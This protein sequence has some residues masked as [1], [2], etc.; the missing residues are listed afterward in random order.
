[1]YNR[2]YITGEPGGKKGDKMKKD[3]M[4]IAIPVAISAMTLGVLL[5]FFMVPR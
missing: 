4:I 5:W 1:M 2:T 3:L